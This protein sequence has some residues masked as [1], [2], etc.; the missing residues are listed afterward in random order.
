MTKRRDGGFGRTVFVEERSELRPSLGHG[1]RAHVRAAHDPFELERRRTTRREA[2]KKERHGMK[3]RDFLIDEERFERV[4]IEEL[5]AARD[6]ESRAAREDETDL[7]D[8]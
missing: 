7:L 8:R 2:R 3:E 5:I 1:D 6:D 4:E